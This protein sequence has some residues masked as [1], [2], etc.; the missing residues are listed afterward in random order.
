[1]KYNFAK[2][3]QSGGQIPKYQN[4]SGPLPNWYDLLWKYK[5]LKGWDTSK[6]SS[7]AGVSIK[8]AY[9]GHAGDLNTAFQANQDYTNNPNLVGQDIQAVAN[10]GQF[11]DINDF[12]NKYNQNIDKL[13]SYFDTEIG[14]GDAAG[15][16]NQLFKSMYQS[17]STAD[18][19]GVNGNIGYQQGLENKSGSSTWLRRG[20]KYE[21]EF[22]DL[23]DDEKALRTHPIT[24]NGSNYQVYKK[25]NGHIKGLVFVVTDL[26]HIVCDQFIH[27]G[28]E[29]LHQ[30]FYIISHF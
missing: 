14:Y 16:H 9:H 29:E 20:D 10:S 28:V 23:T 24:L 27:R 26:V 21:T 11:T 17:R 8:N 22:E 1:M 19:T 7:E 30:K 4:A 15:E 2:L 18:N 5:A 13:N 6:D 12:I 3:L 25:A